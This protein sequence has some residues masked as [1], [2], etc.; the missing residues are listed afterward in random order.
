MC[1]N[2]FNNVR[3]WNTKMVRSICSK[4]ITALCQMLC[5]HCRQ[6][7]MKEKN[8]YDVPNSINLTIKTELFVCG[9]LSLVKAVKLNLTHPFPHVIPFLSYFL[10]LR[11]DI[12]NILLVIISNLHLRQSNN[13][14]QIAPQT[15]RQRQSVI[16]SSISDSFMTLIM[17]IKSHCVEGT[18][19][20]LAQNKSKIK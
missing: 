18:K 2:G 8:V 9:K 15:Q 17:T 11:V 14:P 10:H 13:P 1:G 16:F 19:A 6:R 5:I 7:R 20:K 12:S 4:A 3:H